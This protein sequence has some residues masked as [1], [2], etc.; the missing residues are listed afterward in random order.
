VGN[1]KPGPV[2]HKLYAAYQTAKAAH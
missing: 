1:G 2:Y